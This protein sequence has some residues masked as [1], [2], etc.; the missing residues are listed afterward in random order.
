VKIDGKWG[1]IGLDGRWLLEPRFDYLS[2]GADIF[3][4]SISRWRDTAFVTVS[5]TTGVMRLTD[6]SW[7][8]PPRPGVL[9]DVGTAITSQATAS[10]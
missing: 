7:I 9:C 10:A 3:V 8:V 1:R 6:R 5:G 2:A 4:A